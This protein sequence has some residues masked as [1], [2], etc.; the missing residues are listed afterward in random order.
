MEGAALSTW[1]GWMGVGIT[2]VGDVVS[3]L[4]GAALAM[5]GSEWG[6]AIWSASRKLMG[7]I[8]LGFVS[9]SG[10]QVWARSVEGIGWTWAGGEM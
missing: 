10:L 3:L 9:P 1:C 5:L 8:G 2:A 7:Q 6:A 4:W